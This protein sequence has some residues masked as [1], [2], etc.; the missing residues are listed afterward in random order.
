MEGPSGAQLGGRNSGAEV[1]S[2]A[3][4]RPLPLLPSAMQSIDA[5]R[6]RLQVESLDLV[7]VGAGCCRLL[8]LLA[9][10][11][12][13]LHGGM[14][15]QKVAPGACP[16]AGGRRLPVPCQQHA[17]TKRRGGQLRPDGRVG[18][19]QQQGDGCQPGVGLPRRVLLGR[20]QPRGSSHAASCVPPCI[21]TA[22]MFYW[23]DCSRRGFMH[24]SAT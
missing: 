12:L 19:R 8:S 14:W 17:A 15:D 23:R 10:S 13:A 18:G 9:P 7:Q 6:Q 22:P 21:P 3:P 20:S 4:R 5:S 16:G 24:W 11:R 1:P 2:G